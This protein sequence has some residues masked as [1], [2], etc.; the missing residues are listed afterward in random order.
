MLQLG[1]FRRNEVIRDLMLL[2][3][4]N[5]GS[6]LDI[7]KVSRDLKIS[8]PAL[9]DYIAFLEGTY[10]IK[11]VRPFSR[12]R[13][14][15]VR[16]MPKVYVCDSGVVNRFA[17]LDMG[18]IFENSIFQNLRIRGDLNYYQRKSGVEIDFILDKKTACEVKIS[19]QKASVRKLKE[20]AGELG[21]KDWRMVSK[22]HSELEH[23]IYGFMI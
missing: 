22:N 12:G 15:E 6:K 8:R 20:L 23:V 13:S 9:Y 11:T 7:Q 10:F 14:T 17:R 18:H 4:Q 5:T 16:K 3:I 1:D 2:L 21:L 19:P